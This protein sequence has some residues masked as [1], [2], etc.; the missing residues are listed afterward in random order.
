M[1]YNYLIL[2]FTVSIL[3]SCTNNNTHEN[4]NARK[5][6]VEFNENTL[7]LSAE[8]NRIEFVPLETKAKNIVRNSYHVDLINNTYYVFSSAPDNCMAIYDYQGNLK[9]VIRKKGHGPGEFVFTQDVF[10]DRYINIYDAGK[11]SIITYSLNGKH[12]SDKRIGGINRFCLKNNLLITYK[13]YD[14]PSQLYNIKSH[15][16]LNI[17]NIKD[18]KFRK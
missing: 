18:L 13:I 4:E 1:K 8:F 3:N 14:L 17:F 11:A 15:H 5:L 2:L 10:I 9:S 7:N 6:N 16:K 12:L